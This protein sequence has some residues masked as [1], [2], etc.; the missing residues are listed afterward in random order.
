MQGILIL[1]MALIITAILNKTTK[2][3]PVSNIDDKFEYVPIITSNIYAD[4]LIIYITY[5]KLLGNGKSWKILTNWYKK[6]RLSAMIADILIGVIYMIIARAV[7]SYFK[8]KV[9]LLKFAIIAVGIQLVLDYLFYI[10]F[11]IIPKGKNEMID[12]FKAWAK[13]AKMDALWGDSILIVV[14]VVL[15]SMLNQMSFDMNIFI[16]MIGIYLIP[17]I[18][19]KK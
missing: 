10:V 12:L 1:T 17:Y 5:A 6:Y 9:D 15:S 4:L 16:L 3:R 14:G 2:L 8:I 7:V 11:S 19:Y 18:L 13:N